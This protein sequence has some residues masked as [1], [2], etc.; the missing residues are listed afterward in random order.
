MEEKVVLAMLRAGAPASGL[1]YL[2][3]RCGPALRPEKGHQNPEPFP[4]ATG[5]PWYEGAASVVMRVICDVFKA[6]ASWHKILS[7]HLHPTYG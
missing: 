4:C 6:I 1:K 2:V 3:K 5:F 7:D